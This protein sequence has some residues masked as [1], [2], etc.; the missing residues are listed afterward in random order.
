MRG[1]AWVAGALVAG[2]AAAAGAGGPLLVLGP[3]V[4]GGALALLGDGL[5]FLWILVA[6]AGL[7]FGWIEESA[8]TVAGN[9][10]NL[11]GLRWGMVLA[12]SLAVLLRQG[13][14]AVPRHFRGYVLFLA[15][16]AAGM[17]W[18]PARFE[19]LKHVL[20]FSTPLAV[21]LVAVR[22]VRSR[23]EVAALRHAFW[24]G[25]AVAAIV[26][27]TL[28]VIGVGVGQP[29][30]EGRLLH[31]AT[32]PYLLPLF[33]L[34]LAGWRHRGA[35]YAPAVALVFA[36]GLLTL[37]RAT[38]LVMLGML[39]LSAWGRPVRWMAGMA[40]VVALGG[41]LALQYEPFRERV[42]GEGGAGSAGA[43][44]PSV[45]IEGQGEEAQLV[46]GGVS[47]SG[48]GLIWLRTFRHAAQAPWIGH[49]T[50]SSVHFLATEVN[51]GVI[52]PHNE[53]LRVFHD[54]GL[55]G[56]TVLLAAAWLI[57]RRVLRV[58]RGAT[59]PEGKEWALA[60]GLAFAGFLG[61]MVFDNTLLYPSAFTQN[62]FLLLVL[63]EIPARAPG[64]VAAAGE[65]P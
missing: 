10:V 49:G 55:V 60:A 39:V 7:G 62:V 48:R 37:S 28:G 45:S 23:G 47:M 43:L 8:L 36:L 54:L 34:A 56:L 13:L 57:L 17:L 29:L 3:V 63:G 12:V 21:G 20:Q 5:P 15:L 50:G 11:S 65:S 9:T 18:T 19:G 53:Y 59:T 24:I 6:T 14:P 52:H 26:G 31:R 51:V 33:A 32:G 44:S 38:V 61:S 2:A 42:V 22:V 41:A 64:A 30:D 27:L 40:L 46:V 58:H 16:A 4:V 1:G 35:H 25:L